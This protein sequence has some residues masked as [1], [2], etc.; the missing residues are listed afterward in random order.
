LASSLPFAVEQTQ[1]AAWL[2]QIRHLRDLAAR[3]PAAH[4]FV[5]F[6]IPRMGRRADL[7][8]VHAGLIFVVEYKVGAQQFDRSS[9]DQVF[10]YGLD[11]KHF[12]ET[13][14]ACAIVP[15]LVATEAIRG[16]NQALNWD[17]DNLAQLT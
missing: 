10:G 7:I 16:G 17:E 9:K 11:L 1:S 3:L 2:Y 13:S 4:F 15:I 14:H 8:V 6:L 12:H 5:E